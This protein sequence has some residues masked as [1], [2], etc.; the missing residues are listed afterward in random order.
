MTQSIEP[1]MTQS[2]EP[3]VTQSIEQEQIAK[4]AQLSDLPRVHGRPSISGLIRSLPADFIVK[5]SLA[6][7]LTGSGEHLY[8]L[9]R[10]TGQNTRWITR[11]LARRLNLPMK[12]IGYAGLKDRRAVT[13][14]WFSIHLPGQQD[15]D[16]ESLG[17][18]GVEVIETHRHAGKL[19]TGAL[20]GNHFRLVLRELQ[21]DLSDLESRLVGIKTQRI[22]NYFGEQRFG[23][24]GANLTLFGNLER[25]EKLDRAAR[26]FGFSAMRSALFNNYLGQ[27]IEDGSWDSAMSGEIVWLVEASRYAHE[28]AVTAADGP[29][30]PTGLLWG[31]GDNQSTGA[32]LV[33]ENEY[34]SQYPHI[35]GFL[36][37]HEVRMMR[38]PLA[39]QV[40]D[41]RWEISENEAIVEFGLAR[42]Q[43]AT[44]VL[45]E[46]GDFQSVSGAR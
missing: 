12:A 31:Q 45:R 29:M 7:E 15:P 17:I 23:H 11:Q 46:L 35:C 6:F 4:G 13:E 28:P 22:P 42:G 41:L 37:A 20:S 27:R 21:G 16:I 1:S 33:Q 8:V 39:L 10:K 14:Q 24:S 25:P 9:I 3:S 36:C 32:A 2:I 43:Y 38:R 5:E 26:S 40:S 30:W 34:F 18:E 44:V 19:R